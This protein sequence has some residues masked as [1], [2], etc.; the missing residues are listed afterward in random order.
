M[1]IFHSLSVFIFLFFVIPHCLFIFLKLFLIKLTEIVPKNKQ[2]NEKN[3]KTNEKK[4]KL[5]M[6]KK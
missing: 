1:T 5:K 4:N 6:K 3:E 2:K